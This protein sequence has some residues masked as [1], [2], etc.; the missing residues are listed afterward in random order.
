MAELPA[1][2]RKDAGSNPAGPTVLLMPDG[3]MG[4]MRE[5]GSRVTG[6]SPVPVTDV[7]FSLFG[8]VPSCDG[9]EQGSIPG[10]NH[11]NVECK[12]QNEECKKAVFIIHHSLFTILAY[13]SMDQDT[14]LRTQR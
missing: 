5:F 14:A 9:G 10:D 13:R 2:N 4:N 1:F 3:V 8:K 7:V 12:M 6:S 11:R